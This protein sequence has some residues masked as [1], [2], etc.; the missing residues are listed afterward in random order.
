MNRDLWNYLNKVSDE[1]PTIYF[2]LDMIVNG[3]SE[4]KAPIKDLPS[5]GHSR[6]FNFV[7]PLSTK[8]NKDEFETNI[9]KH[10]F[11]RRIGTETFTGFQILLDSKLNEIMPFYNKMFDSLVDLNNLFEGEKSIRYGSDN[12]NSQNNL[13]NNST[14]T[15]DKRFSDTPQNKIDN[16]KDGKYVTEYNF[17]TNQD[18]STSSGVSSNDRTYTETIEKTN[19]NKIQILKEY[20]E[21]L[22]S[23]YSMIYDELED[24]FYGLV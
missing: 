17:D 8:V 13:E 3:T 7:Y 18:T 12:S 21:N 14:T 15:S 20:K 9:L 23:I 19:A 16:I 6:V 5:L 24:C 2:L 10:F 1:P 22:T 11:Q 4:E